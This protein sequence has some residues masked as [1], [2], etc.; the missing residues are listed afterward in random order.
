MTK[1]IQT[2]S[3]TKKTDRR[4]SP[5][6]LSYTWICML[7][8]NCNIE[9]LVF[10]YKVTTYRAFLE[11]LITFYILEAFIIFSPHFLS[12]DSNSIPPIMIND[13]ELFALIMLP[14]AV[15]F[16]ICLVYMLTFIIATLKEIG[17]KC[18][19]LSGENVNITAESYFSFE[20]PLKTRFIIM[21]I[22][23]V[24]AYIGV[25]KFIAF[26]FRYTLDP[27]IFVNYDVF[28]WKI[29]LG[30]AIA[31]LIW[32]LQDFFADMRV[33]WSCI[34]KCFNPSNDKGL[35]GKELN[36]V[37]KKKFCSFLV[38][39]ICSIVTV[40]IIIGMIIALIN[41]IRENGKNATRLFD[42]NFLESAYVLL[43]LSSVILYIKTLF[44]AYYKKNDNNK[45]YPFINE[46]VDHDETS[47]LGK[48]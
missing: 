41:S 27:Q 45:V 11:A 18:N 4:K 12:I 33:N 47:V 6:L 21:H 2:N 43:F 32:N 14:L 38:H 22:L 30:C 19:E 3:K 39:S 20:K 1:R 10:Y 44:T 34:L 17:Y 24:V 42:G 13:N 25:A 7:N 35:K 15:A 9:S 5:K 8:K 48:N 46:F 37:Y 31:G 26:Y 36:K 23:G 16:V 40:L 29:V 28:T